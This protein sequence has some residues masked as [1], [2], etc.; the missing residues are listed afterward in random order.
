MLMKTLLTT[1]LFKGNTGNT[2]KNLIV[3]TILCLLFATN[4]VVAQ[5][6]QAKA[7]SQY[8]FD[9]GYMLNVTLSSNCSIFIGT[10]QDVQENKINVL[11]QDFLSGDTNINNQVQLK[12]FRP[13]FQSLNDSKWAFVDVQVGKKLLISSCGNGEQQYFNLIVSKEE[14]FPII[15]NIIA[16]NKQ[17]EQ[18]KKLI[19]EV[20]RI[21]NGEQTLIFAGYIVSVL[22]AFH[23]KE[24][25]QED[26]A[27]VLTQL[28]EN[29]IIATNGAGLIAVTLRHLI[30][31]ENERALSTSAR[32]SAISRVIDVAVSNSKNVPY[33]ISLMV[34][35]AESGKVN[36]GNYLNEEKRQRLVQ[37][38]QNLAPKNLS[39]KGKTEFEKQLMIN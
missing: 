23:N 9:V 17:L 26:T 39:Q 2:M 7:F 38:Y 13:R 18:N 19:L 25:T 8:Q 16:F 28:L 4:A 30:L 15:Q 14:L 31:R 24:G 35:L 10:I 36:F 32:N 29:P 21:V 20:P 11:A 6:D 5:K 1:N 34:S 12:Y 37:N 3:L 27:V 22:R 33:A